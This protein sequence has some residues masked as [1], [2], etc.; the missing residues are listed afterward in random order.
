[1]DGLD[2]AVVPVEIEAAG[3][4]VVHEVVAGGDAT[5]HGGDGLGGLMGEVFFYR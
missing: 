2:E 3:H 4:D 5:E 1:V